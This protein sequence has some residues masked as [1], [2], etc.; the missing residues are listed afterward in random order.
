LVSRPDAFGNMTPF[1]FEGPITRTVED[2]ALAMS[3][4]QGYD[5][6]DPFALEGQVD[7]IGAL[8]A[9][10][11]G[12][13]IAYTRDYDVFPVDKRVTVVTD[14]AVDALRAAGAIVEEVKIGIKHSHMELSEAWCR[15]CAAKQVV[16]LEGFKRQGIDIQRDHHDDMP[17]EFW[18]WDAIGRKMTAVDWLNDQAI[19]TG[20]YDALRQVFDK[21]D[22]LVAP[23]L[24]CLAVDNA[25]DGNTLGPAEVN[26]EK[27]NRLIGWCMTFLINFNGH[28]AASCPAGLAE[29]GL[30]VGLQIAGRRY[31]DHGVIA[32]SAALERVRPWMDSYRMIRV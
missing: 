8:G 13:R 10:I 2:A 28:P 16:V 26:G 3:A 19:R 27:I 7:F 25:T 32:A 22:L 24:S 18:H 23:T 1:I 31:D 11:K 6:R 17:P 14:K 29:N 4:L 20:V 5:S 9:S 30:P 15:F 21:Y 12:K